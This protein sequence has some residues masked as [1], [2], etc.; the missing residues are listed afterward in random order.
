MEGGPLLQKE[1]SDTKEE[2]HGFEEYFT[3]TGSGAERKH[4]LDR[5]LLAVAGNIYC[6]RACLRESFL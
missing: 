1:E 6:V 5:C 4:P 2:S 3:H